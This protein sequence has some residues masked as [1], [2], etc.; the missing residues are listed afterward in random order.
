MSN[1]KKI[2][3]KKKKEP[4]QV[5]KLT[6]SIRDSLGSV[7]R[8]V[9]PYQEQMLVG[10]VKAFLVGGISTIV[11]LVLFTILVYL[12]KLNPL[13][14]NII[15][16]IIIFIFGYFMSLKY[17]FDKR[18]KKKQVKEYIILSVVGLIFTELLLFGLVTKLKVNA[19][20]IKLLAVIL[21]I[22]IK[23]L[24]RRFIF[25]KKTSHK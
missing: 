12:I 23:I 3:V 5:D 24:I 14:S 19:F 13:L 7:G 21:V 20:L 9:D 16:F 11:D 2:K 15:S 22:V 10:L 8:K 4:E 18:N 1:K 25:N 17:V 6:Q